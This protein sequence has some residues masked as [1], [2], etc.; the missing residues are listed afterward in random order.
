MDHDAAIAAACDAVR[1]RE[2]GIEGF[3]VGHDGRCAVA[4]WIRNGRYAASTMWGAKADGFWCLPWGSANIYLD[5]N[6]KDGRLERIAAYCQNT[7][8][9]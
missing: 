3:S 8:D 5:I 2:A 6:E 7:I 9:P 1:K 4:D